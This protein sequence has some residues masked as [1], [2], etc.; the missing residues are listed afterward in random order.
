M[1]AGAAS[2]ATAQRIA[3]DGAATTTTELVAEEE[4]IALVYNGVSH[5]VMMATPLDLEDFGLGFSLSEGILRERA[6]LFDLAVVRQEAGAEVRMA[7]GLE[8]F[9]QLRERR[10][11]VPMYSATWSR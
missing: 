2:L 8:R 10:R 5:A 9:A 11:H 6:E 7:I 3:R 1:T 4:P